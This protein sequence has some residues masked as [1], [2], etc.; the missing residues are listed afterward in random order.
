[1]Y[2]GSKLVLCL[3]LRSNLVSNTGIRFK[4]NI[5]L[6]IQGLEYVFKYG[7]VKNKILNQI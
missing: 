2:K 1:M 4:I 5:L 6:R 7:P 3:C